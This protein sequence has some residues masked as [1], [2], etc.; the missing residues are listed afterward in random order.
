MKVIVISECEW[1]DE[2]C[3]KKAL[4]PFGKDEENE[5]QEREKGDVDE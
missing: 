1:D 2:E 4:N 3:I 5:K